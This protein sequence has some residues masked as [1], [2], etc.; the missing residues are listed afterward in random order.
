MCWLSLHS[1]VESIYKLEKKNDH[2]G[3]PVG[4]QAMLSVQ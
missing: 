3:Q 1:K 2:L 4:H